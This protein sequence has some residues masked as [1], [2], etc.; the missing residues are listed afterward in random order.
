MIV[1]DDSLLLTILAAL[2][3]CGTRAVILSGWS[4]DRMARLRATHGTDDIYI[5]RNL[6]LNGP[7]SRSSSSSVSSLSST[8]TKT[9]RFFM[10]DFCDHA[11]LFTRAAAVVHHGGLGTT[12]AVLKAAVPSVA[13][14]F[15]FDQQLWGGQLFR[16]GIGAA[17][18]IQRELTQHK[19]EQALGELLSKEIQQIMRRKLELLR[20]QMNQEKGVEMAAEVILANLERTPFAA[21]SSSCGKVKKR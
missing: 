10:M 19:L 7:N 2:R 21:A 13:C 15:A 8:S 6:A 5:A 4:A 3:S 1:R 12:Y 16:L 11:W 9:R 18:I 20:T 14:P 17:P